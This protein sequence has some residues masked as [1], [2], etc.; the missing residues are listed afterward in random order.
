MKKSPEMV[1]WRKS[2]NRST[3]LNKKTT[4][5]YKQKMELMIAEHKEKARKNTNTEA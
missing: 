5:K 2:S 1:T 3:E 4:D